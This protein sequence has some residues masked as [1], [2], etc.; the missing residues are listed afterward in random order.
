MSV[1]VSQQWAERLRRV[2]P[3]GSSTC[4]KSPRLMPEEPGV[5]VRGEGCRVWDA[6]GRE[7]IDYRNA[8]GPITLGYRFPAVDEAIRSQLE[9]GIIFGHPHP[10]EGEVAELICEVV[11]CAERARFLKTGGE[12]VAACTK[13]ARYHTGRD[14]VVQIGY[15]GWLNSLARGARIRPREEVRAA[16]PGVPEAI[17]AL[18]HVAGWNDVEHL[19][20]LFGEIGEQVAAL[21][22]AADYARM[23]QGGTFYPFL[24]ELCDRHGAVLV[25]DEIVTGFRIATGGVQEHFGVTPDLSVFAKGVANG[26]PLGVYC[27]KAEIM[28]KL[29]KAIVSSTYGG[30][31]LSLAAARACIQTY[32]DE[33]VIKHLWRQGERVWS[34]LDDLFKQNGIPCRMQGLHPCIAITFGQDAPDDMEDRFYR[35]AYRHGVSLYQIPYVTYSHQDSDIDETL[36]RMEKAVKEL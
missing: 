4:S 12:A 25:F 30:E 35:A 22:V 19:Q 14:H 27:G 2:V 18:H 3:W 5:I 13:L 31:A 7:Y 36:E 6:D 11:P 1:T 15:N 17:A 10:L 8:L 9:S 20:K 16:P 26:M 24:R 32:R 33:P 21:V 28:E 23:A 34:G 29:D